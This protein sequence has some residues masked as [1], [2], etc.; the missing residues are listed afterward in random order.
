M[1]R[2]AYSQPM[3][4][5]YD[6]A[7]GAWVNC[8]NA[9]LGG[10]F[11]IDYNAVAYAYNAFLLAFGLMGGGGGGANCAIAIDAPGVGGN[12]ATNPL[13]K[14]IVTL[15]V[16]VGGPPR[17]SINIPDFRSRTIDNAFYRGMGALAA[18]AVIDLLTG[19][20]GAG[21]LMQHRIVNCL[22]TPAMVQ[23]TNDLINHNPV[24]VPRMVDGLVSLFEMWAGAFGTQPNYNAQD[25]IARR[26]AEFVNLFVSDHLPVVTQFNM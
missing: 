16:G 21:G 7:V 14:S 24:H 19:S 18:A 6:W 17:Y 3:Y 2:A 26:V 23:A 20:T 25:T 13:N 22:N 10:D 9:V 15:T 5:A 1:Q 11:N 4:E 8:N 12:P